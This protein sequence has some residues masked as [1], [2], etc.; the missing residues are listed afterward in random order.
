MDIY[1]ESPKIPRNLHCG[2]TFC[3]ECLKFDYAQK[4]ILECPVCKLK[5]D[6]KMRPHELAKNYI[7]LEFSLKKKEMLDKHEFCP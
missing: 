3:E 6:P 5:H 1:N 7:A 4:N 2:H